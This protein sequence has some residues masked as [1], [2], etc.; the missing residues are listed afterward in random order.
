MRA[1]CNQLALNDS[2][3]LE[4]TF[5]P[6]RSGL[7]GRPARAAAA[8][9]DVFETGERPRG[10]SAER[11]PGVAHLARGER[12]WRF[13]PRTAWTSGRYRLLVHPRAET[14]C[15]DEAGDAFEH[16]AGA[17]G[18]LPRVAERTF[19]VETQRP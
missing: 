11:E 17:S 6:L 13:F 10:T 7:T 1:R 4:G 19:D 2:R 18:T 3:S 9:G 12:V 5:G 14:P 15:G 8:S 16:S